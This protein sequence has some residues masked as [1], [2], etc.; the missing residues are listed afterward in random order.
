MNDCKK[1]DGNLAALAEYEREQDR[2]T[3]LDDESFTE[4]AL[5]SKNASLNDL[6][7]EALTEQEGVIEA[8]I[9]ALKLGK[10]EAIGAVVES[11]FEQ[12]AEATE[13]YWND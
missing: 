9:D 13:G 10:R 6:M 1:T 5:E 2:L 11:A 7:V 8:L 12:Y 4:K 3:A